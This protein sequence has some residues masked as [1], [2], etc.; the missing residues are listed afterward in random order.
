MVAQDQRVFPEGQPLSHDQGHAAMP[1]C[2]GN[3]DET[4]V[5][6]PGSRV[7]SF[8]S[9]QDAVVVAEASSVCI[10]PDCSAPVSTGESSSGLGST[11]SN[12]PAVA[13]QSMVPRSIIPSRQA[14]SRAPH[15]EVPS[16]PSGGLDISPPS[17]TMETVGA[18]RLRSLNQGC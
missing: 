10:P 15:Q 3:V 2:L 17:R 4:L 1:L 14:S 9:S 6:V 8:M 13:G 16:V 5:S 11:T 7:G 18:H 12:C